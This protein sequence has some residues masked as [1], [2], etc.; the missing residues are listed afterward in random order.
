MHHLHGPREGVKITLSGSALLVLLGIT[1]VGGFC[2]GWKGSR[3]FT[4]A[5]RKLGGDD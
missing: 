4:R 1:F 3:T 2:V 5:T